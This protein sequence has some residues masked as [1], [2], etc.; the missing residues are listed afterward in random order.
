MRDFRRWA[1]LSCA[2]GLEQEDPL[3]HARVYHVVDLR[4][5]RVDP[6]QVG[7]PA[8]PLLHEVEGL[9][10]LVEHRQGEDVDLGE[11]RVGHA[12]LV[13][14]HDEPPV[15]GP[16]PH[17]HHL[18]YGRAAEHHAADVLAQPPGG[19][20]QLRGEVEQVPPAGGVHVVPE[21][22]ELGHLVPQV[23]GVVGVHLL[24]QQGEALPG[25]PQGLAK[26]LDD[27]LHLVG[28]DRPGQDGVLRPEVAVHP[29]YQLVPETPWKVEVDVG[30]RGHVLGYEAF[31]GEVPL[32]GVHVADADQVSDEQGHRRAAPASGGPLLHRRLGADHALVPP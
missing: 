26:V 18:R 28:G 16:G 3:G 6:A 22:R 23:C 25:K 32:Q 21:V 10:Q 5:L 4:V 27:A 13:P 11:V 15:D 14:V 12:V 29:L 19:V 31:Q 7:P 9:L 1:I 2:G 30:E 8:L 20:H 24:R 17:G